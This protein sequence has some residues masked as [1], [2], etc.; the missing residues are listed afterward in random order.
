V[1]RDFARALAARNC[2]RDRFGDVFFLPRGVLAPAVFRP[3]FRRSIDTRRFPAPLGAAA[4]APAPARLL[5]GVRFCF[6]LERFTE[7]LP[8]FR[9]DAFLAMTLIPVV[10]AL[11][12]G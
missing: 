1:A 3:V 11:E 10:R 2:S 12:R 4:R 7:E 8:A 5:D 9:R 6:L